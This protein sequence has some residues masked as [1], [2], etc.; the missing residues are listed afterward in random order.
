MNGTLQHIRFSVNDKVYNRDPD[1]TELGRT[2]VMQGIELI[3]EIGF[4]AFTFK[5]LGAKIGSPESTIYRYFENK[6]KFLLYLTSWY[7]SWMEYRLVMGTNNIEDAKSRLTKAI[8]LLTEAVEKDGN[9]EYINEIK[10]NKIVVSESIKAFHT[11]K[12]DLENK[13]GCYEGYTNLIDRAAGMINDVAPAY[14]Y[15]KMLA[16]TIIE[17]AHQQ[18][19]FAEHLPAL[20]GINKGNR[21]ITDF[22]QN[23]VFSIIEENR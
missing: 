23:M 16:S 2:M 14:K 10:L 21:S 18:I 5:K 11:R 1:S 20:T 8:T 6:H 3:D 17:G 13:Q 4:E 9:F 7:W 15:P 22:F 12:V 19:F